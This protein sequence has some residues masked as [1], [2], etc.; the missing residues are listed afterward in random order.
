VSA[1]S[2]PAPA[3]ARI[4]HE[5]E[6]EK[7]EEATLANG[8]EREALPLDPG[9]VRLP[10]ELW[11]RV[12]PAP[13]A[14]PR[15]LRL[16]RPLAERLGV[17]PEALARPEGVAALAGNRVPAGA[18]PVALAYAGH[19]FG[20][21]VPQ[22]GDGR[23]VLLGERVDRAGVAR[24]VQ[25]KGSG[26]T[27]FSGGGDGRAAAGPVLR[28]YL[29]SEAMA[30]LGVPTTR[31]LAAVATGEPVYR[32]EAL[33]GAVL[34]RVAATHVRIGT[35]QYLAAHGRHEAVARLVDA[36]LARQYPERVGGERPARALLDAVV[37]RTAA[38]VAHWL[39]V[40][41]IHGVMNTDNLQVAG[42]TL[43]YG[44]CAFL[45]AYHPDTVFS[46]IDRGGRYA[47]GQQ[48]RIAHW[49]L[50][51][52]AE[53]LLP[54]LGEDDASAL[55]QAHAALEAF[56]DHFAQ[57]WHGHLLRKIGLATPRA[58]DA[59][60]G[61][62]LLARM[63][64]HG[65]DFTLTFRRLGE[66]SADD[67]SGDGPV[68]ELFGEPSAFDAWVERWRKRLR[69]ERR[70]EGERRAAMRAENPAFIPRNHRVEQA[71]EAFLREGDLG[72]FDELF[73]TLARPYTDQPE[74]AHLA[75]PPPPGEEVR[76]T[77]CGT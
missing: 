5:I 73:A 18:E 36:V 39:A 69:D 6:R 53:T 70:T 15:L 8:V 52:L 2:G 13:V 9:H 75:A 72:P 40:G 62:D 59:A 4:E 66:L 51:R 19:Q 25:L 64:E 32:E 12:E 7:H 29:V 57:A 44:P 16:N 27:P 56:P 22:L 63:A 37:E 48:P 61:E 49:N 76:A 20:G 67:P 47:F 28:E 42:E 54:H 10:P 77:F 14:K 45:D 58:G 35:F 31:S 55:R 33:P 17:D 23:A 43:D 3:T 46:S 1:P 34:T 21:F 26:R 11:V 30:A 24:D 65:A 68:R 60:L 71:L 38:L 41:F 50:A 74:G